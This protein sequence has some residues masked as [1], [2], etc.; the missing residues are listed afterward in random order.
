VRKNFATKIQ[1]CAKS[2]EA[3]ARNDIEEMDR[4]KTLIAE[5]RGLRYNV[6]P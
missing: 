1:K 6:P 3:Q 2:H 4:L 5:T